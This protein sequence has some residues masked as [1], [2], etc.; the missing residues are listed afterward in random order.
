MKKFFTF[1]SVLLTTITFSSY[2]QIFWV[3][4]FE[5]GSTAGE[6]VTAYT[7][8]NGAW[9]Q[10]I[11]STEGDVPNLWYVSC[12]ENGHTSGVC[13]SG[14]VPVTTTATGATLHIGSNPSSLGGTDPGAAYDAGGLCGTLYC[15]N[16][17]KRAVSPTINCTGKYTITMKFYYIMN[18]QSGFDFAT[19]WY[20]DG[21]TWSLLAS[22]ATT[23][24]CPGGQGA[25]THYS[26]ALPASANNNPNVKIGFNWVNNDDGIGSDPSF[27]VDS[28]SLTAATGTVTPTPSY[29]VSTSSPTCID[30]N[31][32]FTNTSTGSIDSFR[33]TIPGGTPSTSTTSPVTTSFS[34]AGTYTVTLTDYHGGTPYTAT[35]VVTVNPTPHPVIHYS[36]VHTLSVTGTG[37][38]G[39]Q[40]LNGLSPISG[41]TTNTYTSASSGTY[42]VIVDSDGCPGISAAFTFSTT[43]IYGIN[44]PVNNYW[45]FKNPTSGKITLHSGM[46]GDKHQCDGL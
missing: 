34:V 19:V 27:A 35:H 23:I 45:L 22:P 2:G 17:D 38:T 32:H 10:T 4:N 6:L 28:V 18:G 40:W 13:G 21:T 30:T 20:F 15:V 16:T 3:E 7:G 44:A 41:A 29:T 24:L 12:A 43:G 37:Y 5:S 1:F 14:C 31:V 25:W 11:G 39:Y 42:Y 9:T 33:W 46:P 26:V 36:G 8:P